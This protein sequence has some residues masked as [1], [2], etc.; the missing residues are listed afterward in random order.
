MRKRT[1]N[2]SLACVFLFVTWTPSAAQEAVFSFGGTAGWD[3]FRLENVEIRPT[4]GGAEL[5]LAAG[6]Y[7]AGSGAGAVDLLMHFNSPDWS[8]SRGPYRSAATSARFSAPFARLGAGAIAFENNSDELVLIPQSGALFAPGTVWRDFSIEFWIY[9]TVAQDGETVLEWRGGVKN[10]ATFVDQ[11]IQVSFVAQKLV[12]SFDHFFTNARGRFLELK[13]TGLDGILPRRWSHHLLRFDADTGL[14]E[15]LADGK[16]QDS[17]YATESGRESGGRDGIGK[18]GEVFWGLTGALSPREIRWGR[19]LTAVLDEVRIVPQFVENPHLTPFR[20]LKG[21]AISPILDLGR[22]G[23]RIRTIKAEIGTPAGTGL[24]FYYRMADVKQYQWKASGA[25]QEFLAPPSPDEGADGSWIPFRPG[26]GLVSQSAAR[27]R[28]AE[29]R[30]D[31]LPDG[32][33]GHSPVL[34]GLTVEYLANVPPSAPAYVQALAR[35]GAVEVRWLPVTQGQ[36]SGYRI[37]FGTSPGRYSGAV[38]AE[39]SSPLDAGSGVPV[40]G[41]KLL[42]FTLTGLENDRLYY[43]AVSA[44][45]KLMPPEGLGGFDDRREAIFHHSVFSKEASARPTRVTP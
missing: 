12:W 13:L 40:P 17:L 30:V 5:T 11:A 22:P 33:G 43:F 26:S 3:R 35:N 4:R 25:S 24:A 7:E 18:D 39:G 14:V 45:E 1:V 28:Y 27:G 44:Y 21:T 16:I 31:F 32:T 42:S 15:Y 8:D 38:S 20:S 6:E 41:E 37:F 23:S 36:V 2:L 29:I 19:G 34:S 10:G 9:P